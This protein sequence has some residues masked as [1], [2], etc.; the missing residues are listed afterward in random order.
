MRK[1]DAV[2]KVEEEATKKVLH[3]DTRATPL[4]YVLCVEL[5]C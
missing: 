2:R 5:M 1:R 3:V 4:C